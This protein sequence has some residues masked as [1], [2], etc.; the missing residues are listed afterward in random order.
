MINRDDTKKIIKIIGILIIVLFMVIY[1][2]FESH[3][4]IRGP[5]III[6]SPENGTLISTS[7][8]IIHG[9]ALRVKD[10]TLNNRPILIDQYGNFEEVLLLHPGYNVSLFYGEDKFNRTI[11]YKFELVYEK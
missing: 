11:K 4:L 7:T 5:E 8:V 9:K 1:I 6:D 10:I 2:I 3:S